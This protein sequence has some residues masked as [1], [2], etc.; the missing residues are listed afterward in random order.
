MARRA[1]G[2]TPSPRHV[3]A[4]AER[5]A[6]DPVAMTTEATLTRL[7]KHVAVVLRENPNLTDK[8]VANAARLRLRAEMLKLAELSA[9]ARRANA[10]R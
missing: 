2:T 7:A 8:Q 1:P 5:A 6:E 10:A 4:R 3:I 9:E